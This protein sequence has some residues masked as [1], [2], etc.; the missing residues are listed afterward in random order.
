M[1]RKA[2]ILQITRKCNNACV[3]CSNPQFDK[4]P[5]IEEL[6]KEIIKF[7]KLGINDLFLSGGEPTESKYLP[8]LIEFCLSKDIE[9]RI[10][11]NCVNLSDKGLVEKLD[12]AG[13]KKIH[14]S[15]HT[16]NRD[17]A[18]KLCGKNA[19]GK[20][21]FDKSIAG[22]RNSIS[23]DWQVILN[24]TINS[25]NADHLSKTAEFF[26][27]NFPE[28]N[29][30]VYNNLDPGVSDGT[31]Q[32]RAGE[33]PWIVAK[34]VDFE[35]ELTKTARILKENR[36]TFR[37][38]RVP[39]CYMTGFEENSTETRKIVKGEKYICSF[40]DEKTPNITRVVEPGQL[41]VKV[42][43]CRICKL[44]EICAGIQK[45]YFELKGK[46]EISAVFSDPEKIKK[47]IIEEDGN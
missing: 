8:E 45:E 46:W 7:G 36:K 39:L 34:F 12:K 25:L 15:I 22:L 21:H 18:E 44:N 28:I 19:E 42:S 38:E 10:I 27:K 23:A 29:H 40:I 11:T 30:F 1:K 4:E 9:P 24:S 20:D 47:K 17:V 16:H 43:D 33:N 6:K 35:L 32:S 14:A 13:L 31:F 5:S 37:V 3:F 2:A 26:I 41:R